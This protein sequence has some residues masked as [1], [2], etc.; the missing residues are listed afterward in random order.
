MIRMKHEKHG[1]C[2]AYDGNE[3]TYLR[4]IG[5]IAESEKFPS[6]IA[7][8]QREINKIVPDIA[9]PGFEDETIVEEPPKRGPGRPKKTQ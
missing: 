9:P 2:H 3:E 7:E 6:E 5:W 8:T 1:F 4:D